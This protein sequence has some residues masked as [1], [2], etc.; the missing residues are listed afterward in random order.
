VCLHLC[1]KCHPDG[2]QGRPVRG[3]NGEELRCCTILVG[4]RRSPSYLRTKPSKTPYDGSRHISKNP[5]ITI[6]YIYP[7]AISPCPR[8]STQDPENTKPPAGKKPATAVRFSSESGF[9]PASIPPSFECYSKFN[10]VNLAQSDV[11]VKGEYQILPGCYFNRF[12]API[13]P[14]KS[15]PPY[16]AKDS[17][18]LFFDHTEDQLQGEA[19]ALK[20]TDHPA[21]FPLSG[22]PVIEAGEAAIEQVAQQL[23]GFQFAGGGG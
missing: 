21:A 18:F 17:A 15:R 6:S 10:P 12:R 9:S 5:K 3:V 14:D 13:N 19:A 8:G 7:S 2:A 11:Q 1:V 20:K 23:V 22:L 16:H 4:R